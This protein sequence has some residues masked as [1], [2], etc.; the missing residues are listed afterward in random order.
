MNYRHVC[1]SVMFQWSPLT[2]SLRPTLIITISPT[3]PIQP[4]PQGLCEFTPRLNH[5]CRTKHTVHHNPINTT[6]NTPS[7]SLTHGSKTLAARFKENPISMKSGVGFKILDSGFLDLASIYRSI[8]TLNSIAT[9]RI[10]T[11]A[12][13]V[14]SYNI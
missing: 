2:W 8:L 4:E 6:Q 13:Y 1:Q 10:T 14:L 5:T 3:M 11:L 12:G 7:E 9:E